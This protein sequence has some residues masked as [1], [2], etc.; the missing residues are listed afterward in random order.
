MKNSN[1]VLDFGAS[2]E[3]MKDSGK[4]YVVWLGHKKS[5]VLFD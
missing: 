4:Y 5:L 2:V 3:P 1:Y